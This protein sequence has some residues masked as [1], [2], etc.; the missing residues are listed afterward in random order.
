MNK[1]QTEV[2]MYYK[3][4]CPYCIRARA[5]LQSKGVVVQ[6]YPAAVDDRLRQE[7]QERSNRHTYPQIFINGVHIGGCDDLYALEHEGQLDTLLH[8]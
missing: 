2:E 1:D 5:L 4:G 6:E 3:D 8:P 7:M